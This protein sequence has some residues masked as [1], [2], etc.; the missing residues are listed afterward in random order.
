[1]K[2]KYTIFAISMAVALVLGGEVQSINDSVEAQELQH[3]VKNV[4]QTEDFNP[5]KYANEIE[6]FVKQQNPVS[7]KSL[8]STIALKEKADFEKYGEA[9]AAQVKMLWG[10]YVFFDFGFVKDSKI[11]EA[12]KNNPS[13]YAKF[14]KTVNINGTGAFLPGTG[15]PES[16]SIKNNEDGSNIDSY[17]YYTPHNPDITKNADKTVVMHGG[18]RG[19]YEA[20]NDTPEI[21]TFYDKGYNILCVDNRATSLSGGDYVTFGQYESDDVQA[22][23][24]H[25]LKD[26]PDQKIVLYGGSMG[27]STMM[28]ALA[29]NYSSNIKGI[30]ENCG[31]ANIRNELG[32]VYTMAAIGK[33]ELKDLTGTDFAEDFSVTPMNLQKMMETI[34]NY[35]I[36]PKAN[37]DIDGNLP[38]QGITNAIMPKLFIY[39]ESDLVV[40]FKD[41]GQYLAT[42]GDTNNNY[43]FFVPKA[44]HG[45][46]QTID[47]NGYD[48]AISD[49]LNLIFK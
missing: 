32:Y 42:L 31:F 27:A 12:I 1:M 49:Y 2:K 16:I 24:N 48:K 25:Y 41:N 40:P 10:S 5:T 9:N 34:N 30:I 21:R 39:G 45:E 26:K 37:V 47:G 3:T 44:G 20:G 35:Y 33:N 28:S 23:I 11:I 22:W 17:A 7:I 13:V 14:K 29:K 18:F 4:K 36:K 46:A 8:F 6:N 19:G 38:A 43:K 15:S